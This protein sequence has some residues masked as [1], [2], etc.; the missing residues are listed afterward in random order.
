MVQSDRFDILKE[1]AALGRW[2][3]QSFDTHRKVQSEQ[4][5]R[6]GDRGSLLSN[7]ASRTVSD[8]IDSHLV[9]K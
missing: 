4:L 1:E 8:T 9:G 5:D 6:F 3:S 2:V 7:S